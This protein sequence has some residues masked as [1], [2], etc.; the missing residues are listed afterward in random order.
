MTDRTYKPLADEI[1]PE[2]LDDV[3]GQQ[4]ILGKN[5]LLRR[6]VESGNTPNMIFYGPSGTG[7]TTV[8]RIIAERTQ[9]SLRKL[10]A[11]TA[12]IADIKRIIDELDTFLTPGGV[13]LY[14]DEIQ[15][16]NKKQQQSLL[17]FIED[18]R[19]TLIASTTE[20]P[21]F[22]VFGAILSRSTVFEF[23]PVS[24]ADAEAAVQRA[25]RILNGQREA[26]LDIED[27]VTRRIAQACGGDV[28]KAINAV[29]LLFSASYGRKI[30]TLEDAVLIS[31]KSAMRY[32]KDGD[33]HYDILSAMM[34][35]LRG[36]DPDAALHYLARAIEAG[37]LA[38][39]CRR[40]LCSASEDIG[41]A[42]PQVV[43][44]VKACV[45]SAL[46]LGLPEARLPLA[47]ACI[48]LAT[49]P[50]S[51]SVVMAIDEA[52]ADVKAGKTGSIPRELQNVHADG[53]GFEREQGY[54]YPHDYPGHWVFQQY[55]PDEL[56]NRRYYRYSDNKTE[57]AAKKYWDG[58]KEK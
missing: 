31:Q 29:E 6:I 19:I 24:T 17:E 28:R 48:L 39:I 14:L 8:A 44:I 51:N 10:N 25:V 7:K 55:L 27:G 22:C 35:S 30:I 50:K 3:V 47:E 46:Q 12:G 43:P 13:L 26:P 37:D 53:T 56:K 36:S 33:E 54:L 15:Y 2:N 20:N 11:T 45:D 34:K 1:R 42:Y 49:S 52:I 18:G 4:H 58:I 23:K 57:Q 38:G 40:I 16:F 41:M 9:R 5:G 32:D 21:Y